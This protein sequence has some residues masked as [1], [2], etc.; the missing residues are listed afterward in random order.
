MRRTIHFLALLAFLSLPTACQNGF[1]FSH[2][3]TAPAPAPNPAFVAVTVTSVD[4]PAAVTIRPGGSVEFINVSGLDHLI[5]PDNG[6]G[7]CVTP[8]PL[9]NGTSVTL[10]FPAAGTYTYHD[11]YWGGYCSDFACMPPCFGIGG[12]IRVE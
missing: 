12:M 10:T 11:T 5:E 1:P 3:T 4:Y 2:T 7:A 9:N 8:Y 6:A